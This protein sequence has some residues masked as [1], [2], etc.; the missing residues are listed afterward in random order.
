MNLAPEDVISMLT[1]LDPTMRPIKEVVER[2]ERAP[3]GRSLSDV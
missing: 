2:G 3:P 1:A